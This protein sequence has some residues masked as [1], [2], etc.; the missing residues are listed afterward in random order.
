MKIRESK[1]FGKRELNHFPEVLD[2]DVEFGKTT[3]KLQ[4]EKQENLDVRKLKVSLSD[5]S[6]FKPKRVSLVE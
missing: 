6:V 2:V 5:G 1:G 4:L 3:K